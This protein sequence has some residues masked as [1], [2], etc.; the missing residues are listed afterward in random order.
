MTTVK[1]VKARLKSPVNVTNLF[2]GLKYKYY[3]YEGEWTLLPNFAELNPVDSGMID[4]FTIAHARRHDQ[5]GYVFEGF[6]KINK[7]GIYTFY[8]SSDDGSKLWVADSLI[9]NNDGL[10]PDEEVAGQIGLRKGFYPIKVHF[11]RTMVTRH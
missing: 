3:E 1:F 4:K 5:I 9:I 10:H 11:L 2:P 6:V 7:D 8:C